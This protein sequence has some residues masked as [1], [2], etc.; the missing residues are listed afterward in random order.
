MSRPSY[1]FTLHMTFW[2][3]VKLLLGFGL[4]VEVVNEGEGS[5]MTI[6]VAGEDTTKGYRQILSI[7]SDG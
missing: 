2:Q 4:R 7:T 3:R 5:N 1:A 6:S